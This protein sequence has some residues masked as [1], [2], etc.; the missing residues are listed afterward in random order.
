MILKSRLNSSLCIAV[1]LAACAIPA[2]AADT[3]PAGESPDLADPTVAPQGNGGGP[4][5]VPGEILVKWKPGASPAGKSRARAKV[6][7]SFAD[8]AGDVELVTLPPGLAISD[9]ARSL[10]SDPDV[11]LAEPNFVYHHQADK[12]LDDGTLW[13]MG[14]AGGGSNAVGAWASSERGSN[15]SD[16]LSGEPL[17]VGVIDEGIFLHED[18]AANVDT[19][20]NRDFS[21]RDAPYYVSAPD[22]HGTHVSGTIGGVANNTVGVSG[23]CGSGIKMFSA[24]FLVPNR[25]GSTLNAIKAV[26]YVTEV[27]NSG[28]KVIA[29]NNSWG[30]G[31]F[32]QTLKD[33]IDEAGAAGVLFI[34]AAGND[35]RHMTDSSPSYPASYASSN[36]ISVA[37]IDSAGKLASF[38]NYGTAHVDLGAPGVNIMSTVPKSAKGSVTSSYAAYNGTSMATPHV[39]GAAVLYASRH[40]GA[41]ASDI[42]A[43]IEGSAKPNDLLA[44]KTAGGGRQL[45][46]GGF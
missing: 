42:K 11:E 17:Y 4:E 15:C 40:P 39:T 1:V 33:A 30:G 6:R 45:A 38:S 26:R 44:G 35:S 24:K 36:I 7:G 3:S 9:A 20:L 10:A 22:P 28:K 19:N 34:A 25:G 27:K 29:S 8:S 37:A 5:H 32:S 41:T 14:E 31:G 12:Y 16:A 21:K 18:L 13:G 23:V 43:A 2:C 46:V